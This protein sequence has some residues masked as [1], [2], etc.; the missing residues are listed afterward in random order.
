MLSNINNKELISKKLYVIKKNDIIH[1]AN[2]WTFK[3]E[4]DLHRSN[5]T[6]VKKYIKVH[7]IKNGALLDKECFKIITIPKNTKLKVYAIERPCESESEFD[8]GKVTFSIEQNSANSLRGIFKINMREANSMD[9]EDEKTGEIYPFQILKPGSILELAEKWKFQLENYHGNCIFYL[10]FQKYYDG[11][12]TVENQRFLKKNFGT[13]N[14]DSTIV[15]EKGTKLEVM[16]RMDRKKYGFH[17]RFKILN[18][19]FKSPNREFRV[20]YEPASEIMYSHMS[21]SY[22]RYLERIKEL[23]D[24]VKLH[25]ETI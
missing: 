14:F 9:Y 22:E 7:N 25:H 12:D 5:K 19:D 16:A 24:G 8:D 20:D 17:I 10:N 2:N 4:M 15:L 18:K 6:F 3:L 23:Y 21:S 1:V 11:A 13:N